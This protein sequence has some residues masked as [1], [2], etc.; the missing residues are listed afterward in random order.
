[1]KLRKLAL[2]LTYFKV[3][4]LP[5]GTLLL[6]KKIREVQN[7]RDYQ[8]VTGLKITKITRTSSAFSLS[9]P[10]CDQ[11]QPRPP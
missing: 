3:I 6:I 5:M 7:E 1:M 2:V 8:L 4:F 9:T 11:H 10:P